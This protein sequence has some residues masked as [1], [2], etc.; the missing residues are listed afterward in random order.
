MVEFSKKQTELMRQLKTDNLKRINLLEGAVRSG[1]TWISLIL[2]SLW[3]ALQKKDAT[4]LM[5][6]KTLTSLKRNCLDELQ[7]LVGV[8]NFDYNLSKKE[9]VLFGRTVY[10]EGTNDAR[11][12]GKIRGM[13]LTG[14]Y[15]DEITLFSEDFFAMLLSRLSMPG[16]K[17]FATTNPDSPQH[18]LMVKYLKRAAKL[19]I[20]IIRFN[21]DDNPFLP[22]DYVESLKKEYTGVFYKRFILGQWV[23]AEGACY[24]QFADN[25]ENYIVQ[26]LPKDARY[27]SIGVDWGG[28]R[29]LTAFVATVVHGNY[30][31]LTVIKDYHIEG[32]KGEIDGNRVNTEFI[33][34]IDTLRE[35]YPN[36]PIK[37]VFAD[38]AEQYL[39]NGLRKAITGMGI[40][41]GD[42]KKNPIVQRIICANSLLNTERLKIMRECKYVI[43]GLRSAVWDAKAAANGEDKRLD[44]FTSDIDVIDA[45]EYSFERFMSRLTPR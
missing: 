23:V 4:F 38:S 31:R 36:I 21:I 13:T 10:L 6:G 25:P 26:E 11:A 1:K 39:I 40:Q 43:E 16:A 27:I 17:L 7:K 20:N 41:I 22:A 24:P 2:F 35:E 34:F 19:D 12:E 15:C 37:Y 18:W 30:D 9:A 28:N 32:R 45:F 44:D 8:N 14:A 3:V 33:R 29:S 42:S 5:V